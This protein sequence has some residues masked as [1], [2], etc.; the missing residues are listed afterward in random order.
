MSLLDKD[1]RITVDEL[2]KL[3]SNKEPHLL[4]DVRSIPEFEM[5]HLSNSLNVHINTLEKKADYV[6]EKVEDLKSTIDDPK[7][8]LCVL[9]LSI[10]LHSYIKTQFSFF[11]VV[12]FI[13][14]RG[15]DSQKAVNMLKAKLNVKSIYDV[16][17]GL[18]AWATKIDK[19][20]PIY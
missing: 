7:G 11:P 6:I 10:V 16:E 3:R 1:E 9:L 15:N 4:I 5:C 12:I 8:R 13:C 17:G 20:F 18:Y 14:R 2:F 19:Q